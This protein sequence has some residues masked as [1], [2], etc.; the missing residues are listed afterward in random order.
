MGRWHIGASPL[1]HEN[2]VARSAFFWG[3]MPG[4]HGASTWCWL[5]LLIASICRAEPPSGREEFKELTEDI[6]YFLAKG[7]ESLTA[8][9]AERLEAKLKATPHNLDA[10]LQLIGYYGSHGDEGNKSRQRHVLSLIKHHP[11]SIV[12]S[13][14]AVRIARFAGPSAWRLFE[15]V[16]LLPDKDKESAHKAETRWNTLIKSNEDDVEILDNAA[17]FFMA[18]DC[19]RSEELL[20]RAHGMEPTNPRLICNILMLAETEDRG[21]RGLDEK[22]RNELGRHVL[23]YLTKT[24]ERVQQALAHDDQPPSWKYWGPCGE[25]ILK[26]MALCAF[27]AGDLDLARKSA[28]KLIKANPDLDSVWGSE[29]CHDMNELIGRIEI[30]KGS[31]PLAIH[32]LS[33]SMEP[34]KT[35]PPYLGSLTMYLTRDLLRSGERA[36]VVKHVRALVESGSLFSP[37][38]ELLMKQWIALI[39][40]GGNPWPEISDAEPPYKLPVIHHECEQCY[41]NLHAICVHLYIYAQDD[42]SFPESLDEVPELYKKSVQEG[43]LTP[44]RFQ[45]SKESFRCS[46]CSAMGDLT[47]SCYTYISGQTVNDDPRN[48]LIYT[49]PHAHAPGG[50]VL[51]L[52]G[53]VEYLSPYRKVE[54]PVKE[55]KERIANRDRS[56]K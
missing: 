48:V 41:R 11:K 45:I 32:S 49:K 56:K 47:T 12:F 36:A 53:S 15:F 52:D 1:G 29:V 10:R 33:S 46:K 38:E 54:S 18:T 4:I 42:D 31:I 40:K 8:E 44:K 55:S 23:T 34:F 28:E 17:C 39:E 24:S 13:A 26:R 50:Y 7:E 14:S 22:K 5:V 35:G 3:A 19:R 37:E 6:P 21:L 25:Y 27:D 2:D 16:R 20:L 51:F 9:E 30:Q 43:S